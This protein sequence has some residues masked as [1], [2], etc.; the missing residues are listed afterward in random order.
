M[1][2]MSELVFDDVV[3]GTT[4][5]Y[6]NAEKNTKLGVPDVWTLFVVASQVTGTGTSL[7]IVQQ[8]SPNG[9]DWYDWATPV[10]GQ[11]LTAGSKNVLASGGYAANAVTQVRLKIS[12]AGSGGPGARLQVWVIGRDFAM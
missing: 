1:L 9:V 3:E 7:T 5:V 6:S 11:S 4:E 8:T 10:S 2:R 12:L